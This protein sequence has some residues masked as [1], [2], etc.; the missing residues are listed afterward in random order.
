[1]SRPRW[2]GRSSD[3]DRHPAAQRLDAIVRG[4][5]F[6]SQVAVRDDLER[7]RARLA[8]DAHD[9]RRAVRRALEHVERAEVDGAGDLR[10]RRS[11]PRRR[12][13]APARP[14]GS[15]P[16]GAPRRARPT[17]SSGGKTRVASSRIS[18]N[19]R[20]VSRCS[21]SRS[22][23]AAAGSESSEPA[24]TSRL[25]ASPTRSCCT[26]SC[27][28]RSM[29]RRS[30]S[31]A[32]A[33]RCREARSSSISRRS[34][35]RVAARRSA[36]SPADASCAWAPRQLSVIAR[37]AS[38][39]QHGIG[40]EGSTPAFARPPPYRRRERPPSVA[41]KASTHEGRRDLR[42]DVDV[43]GSAPFGRRERR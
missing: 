43:D 37:A 4:A 28:A 32:S 10:R 31:A 17:S 11:R 13:S 29:P 33:S 39:G 38:S 35:S 21:S 15:P 9:H 19:A 20:R 3:G 40:P 2:S 42:P 34:P 12:R 14:R 22:A 36:R 1:M 16:R 30:A 24:A 41:S 26:P 25:A 23:L 7:E 8:S 6:R 5:A 18:V 27:R